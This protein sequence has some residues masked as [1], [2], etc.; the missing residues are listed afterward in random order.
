M[1]TVIKVHRIWQ[2]DARI[3]SV[4]LTDEEKLKDTLPGD[5]L[6]INDKRYPILSIKKTMGAFKLEIL[7][8]HIDVVN[9]ADLVKSEP[10]ETYFSIVGPVNDWIVAGLRLKGFEITGNYRNSD[11]VI[12]SYPEYIP[13]LKNRKIIFAPGLSSTWRDYL[14]FNEVFSKYNVS[15]RYDITKPI[16]VAEKKTILIDVPTFSM[17]IAY[18]SKYLSYSV[19][20]GEKGV[21]IGFVEEK[22]NLYAIIYEPDNN[23]LIYS[24]LAMMIPYEMLF[25]KG[26][27]LDVLLKL[28]LLEKDENIKPTKKETIQRNEETGEL[29]IR[30]ENLDSRGVFNGILDKIYII[31]G[32]LI[33]KNDFEKKATFS[34]RFDDKTIKITIKV[35]NNAIRIEIPDTSPET[36]K[37]VDILRGIITDIVNAEKEKKALFEKFKRVSLI[38][39]NTQEK[40]ITIK[41]MIEVDMNPVIILEELRKIAG[42][43][44]ADDSFSDIASDIINTV[45]ALEKIVKKEAKLPDEIKNEVLI[46]IEDWHARIKQRILK[47]H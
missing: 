19:R 14:K 15:S 46:K 41:D 36:R 5:F 18:P 6:E 17:K 33:E 11:F 12:I 24:S 23:V 10:R 8:E 25:G 34:I 3:W 39:L 16:Y 20:K 21:I 44:S 29:V 4:L 40:L 35:T 28:L 42:E 45:E 47:Y 7:A 27:N 43:L 9:E 22:P 26:R 30:F 32:L 2:I 1:N 37:V 31:G 38:A 13:T